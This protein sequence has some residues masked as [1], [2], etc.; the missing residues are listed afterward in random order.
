MG[1]DSP[2]LNFSA[3][4]HWF[5]THWDNSFLVLSG[6]T[7]SKCWY[8][9]HLLYSWNFDRPG[10]LVPA[11]YHW[12]LPHTISW[13]SKVSHQLSKFD[14]KYASVMCNSVLEQEHAPLKLNTC[15]DLHK[16][17]DSIHVQT[18]YISTAFFWSDW[19]KQLLLG[20]KFW[21]RKR[22]WVW[23]FL[24]YPVRQRTAAQ[25]VLLGELHPTGVRGAQYLTCSKQSMAQFA[26]LVIGSRCLSPQTGP[27]APNWGPERFPCKV[28]TIGEEI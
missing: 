13:L 5:S 22:C 2:L 4:W 10:S 17:F 28:K 21:S 16:P 12:R 7:C 20:Q 14:G 24:P 27:K 11:L 15:C 26:K 18:G 23:L 8:T 25:W 6:W 9:W 1:V 3:A 19:N